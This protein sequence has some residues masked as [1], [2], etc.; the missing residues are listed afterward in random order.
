MANE[1]HRAQKYIVDKL[2]ASA[3]VTAAVGTR[4][5]S[6]QAPE[7]VLFPYVLFNLQSASD[8]RGVCTRRLLALALFQIKVIS[9]GSPTTAVR[10][11]IDAI[12]D[13]KSVV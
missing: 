4:I 10:T 1:I 7:G 2:T 12:E 5:Y 8:V 13:R 9:K 3:N 11:A 6:D